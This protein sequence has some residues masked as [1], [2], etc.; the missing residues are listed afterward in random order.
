LYSSISALTSD[1]AAVQVRELAEQP[2]VQPEDRV[3][4][5]VDCRP[6]RQFVALLAQIDLAGL[7]P[8][9]APQQ[10]AE[11]SAGNANGGRWSS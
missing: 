2:A 3:P 11:S 7:G 9:L 8:L 5:R 10:R 4:V 6:Q 1:I